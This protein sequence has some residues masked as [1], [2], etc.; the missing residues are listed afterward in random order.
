[1]C[2]K[3]IIGGTFIIYLKI[4]FFS[5]LLVRNPWGAFVWLGEW[6]EKWDGWTPELRHRLGIKLKNGFQLG[7]FWIPFERFVEFFD[8]VDI[9]QIRSH[10]GWTD[11]RYLIN[12]GWVDD[13]TNKCR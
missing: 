8:S 6:S 10:T 1:M 13:E 3:S 5:L 7:T 11:L 9:A 12:I 2:A 4:F